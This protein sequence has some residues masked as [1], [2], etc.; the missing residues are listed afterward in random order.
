MTDTQITDYTLQKECES[1]AQ[2]IFDEMLRDTPA[3]E[4]PDADDVYDKAHEAVDGHQWVIYYHYAH[5]ICQNCNIEEGEQFLEDCGMPETP[6]YDSL[7]VSMAYGEM[8]ARVAA[9]LDTLIDAY[10]PEEVDA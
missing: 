10:E 8:R 1:L 9:A 6:T 3:G 5:Q 7:A 4:S 2:E